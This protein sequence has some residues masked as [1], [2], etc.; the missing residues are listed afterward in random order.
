MYVHFLFLVWLLRDKGE[1]LFFYILN[2]IK[3]DQNGL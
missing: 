3:S 1:D 2:Q